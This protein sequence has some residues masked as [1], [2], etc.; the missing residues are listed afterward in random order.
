MYLGWKKLR[1]NYS[2]DRIIEYTWLAWLGF[3]VAGRLAYG[4]IH[5]GVWNDNW[6]NWVAVWTMPG[7][8][9]LGGYLGIIGVT[10]WYGIGKNWKMWVV[11]E[12]I[13]LGLLAWMTMN[14]LGEL[15]GSGP[16][17][18]LL[19]GLGAAV[20]TIIAVMVIK[21]RYRSFVWYKSGKKGFVF[22]L[23]NVV[24]PVLTLPFAVLMREWW[25]VGEMGIWCLTSVVVLLI[26]GEVIEPPK[27]SSLRRTK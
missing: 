13:T 2:N 18:K 4:C 3:L 14:L 22:L 9:Y 20:A 26:L 24:F 16:D 5:W 15:I 10:Y 17:R 8:D 27:F 19:V 21:P 23:A 11:Y 7:I 12:D 6:W 25:L 1:E